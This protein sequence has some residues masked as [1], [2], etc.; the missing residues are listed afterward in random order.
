MFCS[1]SLGP[2]KFRVIGLFLKKLLVIFKPYEGNYVTE[3]VSV[4]WSLAARTLRVSLVNSS[5]SQKLAMTHYT[6]V[7]DQMFIV[8]RSVPYTMAKKAM[9]PLDAEVW[10]WLIGCVAVGTI[11]I[12][13]VSFMKKTVKYFVFGLNVRAPL[14]NLM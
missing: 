7:D 1:G 14:L 12:V 8:S 10:H 9:L 4:D 13:V 5:R 3:K 6:H 2:L 11:V